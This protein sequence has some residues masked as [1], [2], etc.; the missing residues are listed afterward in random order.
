M[1]QPAFLN[2]IPVYK[3][4]YEGEYQAPSVYI[5]AVK[6][7]TEFPTVELIRKRLEKVLLRQD[8]SEILDVAKEDD[9][10]KVVL[11]GNNKETFL[12]RITFN[13]NTDTD[14]W[15]YNAANYR[16]RN[17]LEDERLEMHL[18]PQTVE[19]FTF[20]D[21][22]NPYADLMIQFAVLD[23][24]AGECYAVVDGVSALF[25]SGAWLAEMAVSYTPPNP[26]IHYTIHA[27]TPENPNE[28]DYWLH[29][30]GLL[31]F[32]LPELEILRGRQEG[33]YVYQSLLN[34]LAAQLLSNPERWLE[35]ELLVAYSQ[36][37]EIWLKLLPWQEAVTSDLLVEKKGFLR[38]KEIPFSGDMQDREEPHNEPSMVLFAS[39]DN[40]LR[41]LNDYGEALEDDHFMVM[42]PDEE[43]A[44][45]STVAHEKLDLFT[46]CFNRY[47]PQENQWGYIMKLACTSEQT[48]ATEHMWFDVL[49]L[50]DKQ[51][52][53][54]LLNQPFNIPEMQESGIYELSLENLTDWVIYSAP[55][56]TQINPDA[57]FEL[58]RFLNRN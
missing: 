13:D 25:F 46:Q 11:A 8:I 6:N 26:N 2:Q 21:L 50:N 51:I 20:L 9:S 27:V 12:Y 40:Q 36:D 29:T 7:Y 5:S 56:Q 39:I 53:G 38:K 48:E 1:S 19:C 30:H 24:V 55:M 14:E 41:P 37:Q 23:A 17:L 4:L 18:A 15:H 58:R 44:R 49:E 33:L 52:K 54:K 45:M 57:A 34:G 31:K 16:N 10:F 35:E 3:Q 43:T 47:P 22:E 42:L 32:G 28:A